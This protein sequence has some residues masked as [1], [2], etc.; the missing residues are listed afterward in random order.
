MLPTAEVIP[1]LT[2]LAV[3]PML[4]LRLE[5]LVLS[6]LEGKG[7]ASLEPR[8]LGLEEL[9]LRSSPPA[10]SQLPRKKSPRRWRPETRE[11]CE[12]LNVEDLPSESTERRGEAARCR[13]AS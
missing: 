3:L 10:M 8:V 2:L 7:G 12:M 6:T 4:P 5:T 9:R 11:A 13:C 1:G